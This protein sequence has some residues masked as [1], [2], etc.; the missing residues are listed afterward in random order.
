MPFT[1]NRVRP[2]ILVQQLIL[3]KY[4]DC[5]ILQSQYFW[6]ITMYILNLG[7]CMSRWIGWLQSYKVFFLILKPSLFKY[8][9]S[10]HKIYL[11][12][13]LS[14]IVFGFFIYFSFNFKILCLR[15]EFW[16]AFFFYLFIFFYLIMIRIELEILLCD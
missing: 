12:L 6:L 14:M 13:N 5:N 9:Y 4:F 1:Y 2:L 10:T 16:A 11:W 7:D 3:K 8:N 15:L